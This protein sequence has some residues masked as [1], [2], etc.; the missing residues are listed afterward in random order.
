MVRENIFQIINVS[1]D[2]IWTIFPYFYS[3]WAINSQKRKCSLLVLQLFTLISQSPI[4]GTQAFIYVELVPLGRSSSDGFNCLYS[5]FFAYHDH[6]PSFSKT[7]RW[8]CHS[9]SSENKMP[10]SFPRFCQHQ[11]TEAFY[12]LLAQVIWIRLTKAS[13]LPQHIHVESTES[14]FQYFLPLIWWHLLRQNVN[15]MFSNRNVLLQLLA[16]FVLKHLISAVSE[17]IVVLVC[18][19][20][21]RN[22]S[23]IWFLFNSFSVSSVYTSSITSTK[24]YN[25][26]KIAVK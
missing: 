12:T 1:C 3:Y 17:V 5:F 11:Y 16:V 23:K 24:F 10:Q 14:F 2:I 7:W 25:D 22:K 21:F 15:V 26:R 19:W 18:P 6:N 13:L 9:V 8:L 4:V 20:V